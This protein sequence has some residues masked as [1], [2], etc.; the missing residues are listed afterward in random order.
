MVGILESTMGLWSD[1]SDASFGYPGCLSLSRTLSIGLDLDNHV[2]RCGFVKYSNRDVAMAA[3][4][5]FNG[6]YTM[7][8]CE[9]PLIVQFDDPKRPRP[10]PGEPRG[11]PA[12]G[13]PGFGPRIPSPG[14]SFMPYLIKPSMSSSNKRD[15]I[16]SLHVNKQPWGH[17]QRVSWCGFGFSFEHL[18]GFF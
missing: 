1:C 17:N 18:F 4:N 15:F 7:R 12:L 2:A 10:R 3:I 13:G 9:Q 8:G 14:I 5:A 16:R 6:I 11:S